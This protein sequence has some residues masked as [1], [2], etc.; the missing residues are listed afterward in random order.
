MT[1]EV[2]ADREGTVVGSNVSH[3]RIRCDDGKLYKVR[4]IDAE[5][6]EKYE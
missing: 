3:L 6:A 1:D 4:H 2:P 5:L